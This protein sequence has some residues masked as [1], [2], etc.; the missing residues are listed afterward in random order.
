MLHGVEN[1]RPLRV[2]DLMPTLNFSISLFIAGLTVVILLT[3]KIVASCVLG[4]EVQPNN[5]H[6]EISPKRQE[7]IYF[8]A[9]YP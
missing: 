8:K 7:C 3:Y 4:L 1:P 2:V 6:E 9:S 5:I